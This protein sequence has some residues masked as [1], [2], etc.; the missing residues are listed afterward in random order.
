MAADH[1]GD[2]AL[3]GFA[4]I[5]IEATGSAIHYRDSAVGR[6]QQRRASRHHRGQAQGAGEDRSV[7]S[8]AANAGRQSHHIAGVQMQSVGR[9]EVFRRQNRRFGQGELLAFDAEQL[10]QH[11]FAD[12]A[13]IQSA[14]RQQRIGN[15]LEFVNSRP[16]RPLPRPGGA[17]TL[18]DRRQRVPH[19][20]RIGQQFALGGEDC[21]FGGAKPLAGAPFQFL[22][23]GP[24]RQQR[25]FQRL[26]FGHDIA[27][28]IADLEPLGDMPHQLAHRQSGTS[29]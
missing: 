18:H 3:I 13:Q 6:S 20:H 11:P 15:L 23:L 5:Q 7:R 27:G 10:S 24:H 2:A 12:I 14:G 19:Q 17:V 9:G 1:L 8:R 25:L 4:Q 21:G 28:L 16:Q 22:A 29:A 26:T